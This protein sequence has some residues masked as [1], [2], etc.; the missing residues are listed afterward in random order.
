MQVTTRC[1]WMRKNLHQCFPCNHPWQ[2]ITIVLSSDLASPWYDLECYLDFFGKKQKWCLF[3]LYLWFRNKKCRYV[4]I[5]LTWSS[6][7]E[8]SQLMDLKYQY[9]S[10]HFT[11][12]F[13]L[14]VFYVNRLI[15]ID[16]CIKWTKAWKK[17][18]ECEVE[19]R[20][21]AKEMTELG[22]Y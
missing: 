2:N 21:G 17:K 9:V 13:L 10:F 15:F 6:I 11:F 4:Q 7:M 14:Y 20:N 22:I 3:I 18:K 19:T 5:I 12:C 8:S 1:Q 16:R